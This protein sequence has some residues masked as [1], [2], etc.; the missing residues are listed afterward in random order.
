MT[1]PPRA[2]EV[3]LAEFQQ[4]LVTLCL[5]SGNT[6]L[7]RKQRDRHIILKSVVLTL[8]RTIHY[9][10]EGVNRKLQ[11]WLRDI[12]SLIKLDHVI[13]RRVLVDEEFLGRS[14]DGSRYW[15]A[16]LSRHQ[17]P[18]APAID[19]LD[20]PQLVAL[21]RERIERR[22]QEYLGWRGGG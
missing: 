7:P 8:D 17:L 16:T 10:E 19:D 1:P 18:F 11:S 20:V 4:R 2:G 21:G 14:Q 6:G 15:V 9:T 5:Q 12:G 3:G 13:L 22:K